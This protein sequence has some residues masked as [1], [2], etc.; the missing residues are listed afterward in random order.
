M[1]IV[2]ADFRADCV[3]SAASCGGVEEAAYRGVDH[4][5][6][7]TQYRLLMVAILVTA[8]KATLC[9]CHCQLGVLGDPLQILVI[10]DDAWIGAAVAGALRTV[11]EGRLGRNL[12]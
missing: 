9:F 5:G 7:V 10:D 4:I 8:G 2:A 3:D 12:A 1:R 6:L 11:I